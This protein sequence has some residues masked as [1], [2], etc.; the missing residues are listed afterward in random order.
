MRPFSFWINLKNKRYIGYSTT[1]LFILFLTIS[2]LSG[3]TNTPGE[4]P[5]NSLAPTMP[6]PSA[7]P[8]L[9]HQPFSRSSGPYLLIQ[10]DLKQYQ[11]IDL[12]TKKL[13]PFNPPG[14]VGQ[15]NLSKLQSPSGQLIFFPLD[16]NKIVV[17]N[18]VTGQIIEIHGLSNKEEKFRTDLAVAEAQSILEEDQYSVESLTSMVEDAYQKSLSDIRW[19]ENDQY[20]LLPRVSN[21]TSTNLALFDLE[22]KSITSLENQPGLVLDYRVGTNK[23]QILIKKGYANDPLLWRGIRYYVL[24]VNSLSIEPI[25]LPKNIDNPT[26][27]WL[28]DRTIGIIHQMAPIGGIDFSILDLNN[29]GTKQIIK[30]AFNHVSLYNGAIFWLK[31][32]EIEEITTVGLSNLQAETLHQRAIDQRCSYK[33]KLDNLILLNCETN[34]LFLNED[35]EVIP[36]GPAVRLLVTAIGSEDAVL[37]TRDEEVFLLN[38]NTLERDPLTLVGTPLE[39]RWLKDGSAFLYRVSGH[40]YIY[41]LESQESRLLL[42]SQ[43]LGDYTNINAIWIKV[44]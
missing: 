23:D 22:T 38:K 43:I 32:S 13:S 10:S 36:F 12:T 1:A 42:D 9:T 2:I 44:E 27:F 14:N 26:L 4:P 37:V 7:T 8:S 20:L 34:S 31:G 33:T 6:H 18:L 41:N 39:I 30:G 3:C 24:D 19:Y 21:A 15:N 11:I 25:P 35:I 17:T 29:G 16:D 5:S 40:L 28:Q